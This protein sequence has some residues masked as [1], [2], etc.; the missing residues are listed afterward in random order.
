MP[1]LSGPQALA[2]MK[3]LR[4]DVRCVFMTGYAPDRSDIAQSHP[5]CVIV[6]K[7]F[8]LTELARIVR[9][10]LDKGRAS[11]ANRRAPMA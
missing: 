4:S 2:K 10:T 9:E 8:E 1:K 11:G 3:A 5:E 7:P 6:G